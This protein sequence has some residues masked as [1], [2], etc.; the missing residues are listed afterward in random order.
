TLH[1]PQQLP[2]VEAKFYGKFSPASGVDADRVSYSTDYELRVPAIVYHPAGATITRHPAL[3]VVNGHDEDK[4][5]WDSY[6]A[7]I[8]YARAGA[9]VLTY[10]AIG[11]YERNKERRSDTLQHDQTAGSRGEIARRMT[12][13]MIT[14]VM[15]AVSY[16]SQRP[17]VDSKRIAM[18]G[19]SMG[20]FIGSLEC[21]LD[22]RVHACVLAGG[23]DLDGPGGHWDTTD[24]ICESIAYQS[25]MFLGDRGA[26][27]YALNAKRGPTLVYNGSADQV[28]D[29]PHH[30]PD[31]FKELRERTAA[32]LGNSKDV[33]DFEIVPGGGHAPYF[34]TKPVALW[35]NDKLKFPDWTKKRIE[36]MPQ[37]R[38]QDW[39]AANHLTE[40]NSKFFQQ[41]KGPLMALGDNVPAVPRADLHAIPEAVWDSQQ[42]NYI[43]ETWLERATAAAASGAP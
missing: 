21:A 2:S 16:L 35:L 29:I 6:W 41:N 15:Q 32:E 13:L 26:V 1:V 8:L 14:D 7:G 18:L 22:T 23:G 33:F 9:V 27:I 25:L 24:K 30:G 42:Q 38:L 11:E 4:S 19:F 3:I 31:F 40:A 36:Q 34:L 37:T 10:D 17:D 43:Y 12:G 39:A 5:S 20:S 28:E